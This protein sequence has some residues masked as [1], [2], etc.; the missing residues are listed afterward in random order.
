MNTR[1]QASTMFAENQEAEFSCADDGGRMRKYR[2]WSALIWAVLL[3]QAINT[4]AQTAAWQQYIY[5]DDGFQASYP[6]P[7]DLQKKSV[8]TSAGEFELRSYSATAADT[9]LIIGVCDYG[10]AVEGRSSD[11]MLLGA[12]NSTLSN[13]ASHLVSEKKIA[14][15]KNPGLQ[16]ESENSATH[17]TV[18]MFMVGTTLYEALVISPLNKPFDQSDRFF[19]SFQLVTRTKTESKN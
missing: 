11:Q 18:R 2:I 1:A 10:P 13:S 8:Q 14:L 19:D 3:V 15:G 5:S 17:F 16:F 12:K 7:P 9:Q 4:P 6:S